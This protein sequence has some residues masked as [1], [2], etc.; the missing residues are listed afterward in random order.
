MRWEGQLALWLLVLSP[1]WS[2]AI[3]EIVF[4]NFNKTKKGERDEQ[5][6]DVIS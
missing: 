2:L 3:R 6:D 1:I 4:I 5:N